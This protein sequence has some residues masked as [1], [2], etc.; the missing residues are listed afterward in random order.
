MLE[1][2]VSRNNTMAYT[3][4]KKIKGSDVLDFDCKIL[5]SEQD[6][7]NYFLLIISFS[8]NTVKFQN[9]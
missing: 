7:A 4:L 5:F 3:L 1:G 2:V 8:L 6:N 9:R